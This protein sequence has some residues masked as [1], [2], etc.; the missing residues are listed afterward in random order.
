MHLFE[1]KDFVGH[2]GLHMQYKIESEA[3][4]QEDWDT[5]AFIVCDKIRRLNEAH[6]KGSAIRKVVGVPRGG[7]P[8]AGAIERY[9]AA[10]GGMD[11]NGIT[12]ILDDVLTTGDSMEEAKKKEGDKNAYGVVVFARGECP[13]WVKP[14]FSIGWW[15]TE[16]KWT[17]D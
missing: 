13:S 11:P 1:K 6:Y 8:F 14:L 17:L 7:I 15:N 5:L 2:S 10:N 16:D 12:L 9:L 3:L 4:T